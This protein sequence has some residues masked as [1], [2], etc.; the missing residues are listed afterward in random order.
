M[1]KAVQK[2]LKDKY[3]DR[4]ATAQALLFFSPCPGRTYIQRGTELFNG[5]SGSSHDFR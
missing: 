4:K 1:L 3:R 2:L 5:I